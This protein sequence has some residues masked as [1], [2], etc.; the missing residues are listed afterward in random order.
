LEASGI[1]V[2][3][4]QRYSAAASSFQSLNAMTTVKKPVA[5]SALCA[6]ALGVRAVLKIAARAG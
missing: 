3:P 2:L 4:S 5:L 1:R 6:Q